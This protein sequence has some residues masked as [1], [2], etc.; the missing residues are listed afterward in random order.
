MKGQG[1]EITAAEA[2]AI[3]GKT[4]FDL[5]QSRDTAFCIVQKDFV[6]EQQKRR[7]PLH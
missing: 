2:A 3:A 7:L 6:A 5:F 4:E 1:T